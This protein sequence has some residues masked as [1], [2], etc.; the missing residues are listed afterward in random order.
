V[1]LG[2]DLGVRAA[3]AD[4]ERDLVLARAQRSQVRARVLATPGR[5]G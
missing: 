4:G 5:A 3:L 2:G 1:Q